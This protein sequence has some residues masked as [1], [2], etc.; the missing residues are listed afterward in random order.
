MCTLTL[1]PH[2]SIVQHLKNEIAS[3]EAEL[4]L[5]TQTTAPQTAQP[6]LQF[7]RGVYDFLGSIIDGSSVEE[8]RSLGAL[9]AN[10]LS[11]PSS[12]PKL[13]L[14][15]LGRSN[16]IGLSSNYPG[17]TTP[18]ELEAVP[19]HVADVLVRVYVDRILPQYPFL[20][21]S[22]INAHYEAAYSSPSHHV[23]RFIV[24][25]AMAISTMTSGSVEID[26]VMAFSDA[27]FRSAIARY[28]HLPINTLETL[29]CTMLVFQ[30]ANFRPG[31][32]NVWAAKETAI[33]TAIALGL[34]KQPDPI[35][36]T[37]DQETLHVRARVFWVVSY[38]MDP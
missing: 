5:D 37:L 20:Q 2:L 33:K 29:Q 21:A 30:F 22:Q 17:E 11:T 38:T 35:W 31:T 23:S 6:S 9:I 16:D 18:V 28:E 34:H 3:M 10:S 15:E 26:K 36:H 8:D 4:C 14:S 25:M 27:L 12:L 24:A 7:Q 32:A 19:K 13:S 1:T